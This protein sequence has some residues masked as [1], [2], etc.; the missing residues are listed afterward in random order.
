M[1]GQHPITFVYVDINPSLI[2]INVHPA[3]AEIRFRDE[4]AVYRKVS[5]AVSDAL[6]TTD[7]AREHF[8]GPG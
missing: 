2:D 5:K 3:K 1:K 6:G 8:S 7:L 4:G